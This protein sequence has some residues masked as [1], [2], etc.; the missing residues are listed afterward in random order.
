M[1]T[2][3]KTSASE[4]AAETAE[5]FTRAQQQTAQQWADAQEQVIGMFREAQATFAKSLPSATEV[6]E[7]GY[8]AAAR[9]LQMQRDLTLHWVEALT[10]R[11]PGNTDRGPGG[12]SG[13]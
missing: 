12:K 11:L 1:A 9:T 10:P 3:T 4:Q 2:E 7:A 8:D 13:R 5:Q 6:I